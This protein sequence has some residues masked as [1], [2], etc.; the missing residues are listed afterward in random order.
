MLRTFRSKRP[1]CVECVASECMRLPSVLRSGLL[2]L[3]RPT[4]TGGAGAV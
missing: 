3:L 4:C 2:R 1:E